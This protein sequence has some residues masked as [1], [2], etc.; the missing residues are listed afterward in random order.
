MLRLQKFA[1]FIDTLAQFF[2]K[3][4]TIAECRIRGKIYTLVFFTLISV[5]LIGKLWNSSIALIFIAENAILIGF[6]GTWESECEW[7]SVCAFLSNQWRLDSSA[8]LSWMCE[9]L[10]NRVFFYTQLNLI[11]ILGRPIFFLLCS[12]TQ[13][14]FSTPVKWTGMCAFACMYVCVAAS[15]ALLIHIRTKCRMKFSSTKN[16]NEMKKELRSY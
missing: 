11:T 9:N 14:S 3:S 13:I 1:E 15:I 8:K 2:F 7:V 6:I 12:R 10:L 4:L 16:K 5:D